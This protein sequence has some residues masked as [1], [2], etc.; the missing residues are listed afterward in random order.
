MKPFMEYKSW[1]W[2]NNEGYIDFLPFCTLYPS[3][4]LP[5]YAEND[6]LG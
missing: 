4:L 2:S 1:L 6:I 3:K 5:G